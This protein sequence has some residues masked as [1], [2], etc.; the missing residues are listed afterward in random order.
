VG[1]DVIVAV[2]LQAGKRRARR[3]DP[4]RYNRVS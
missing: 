1:H 4:H 3:S 2:A